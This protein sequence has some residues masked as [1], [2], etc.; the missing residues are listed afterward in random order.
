MSS[1][2]KLSA[3]SLPHVPGYTVWENANGLGRPGYRPG[4]G[5]QYADVVEAL[6]TV[7]RDEARVIACVILFVFGAVFGLL[8]GQSLFGGKG[9]VI[10]LFTGASAGVVIG[11]FLGLLLVRV[12]AAILVLVPLGIFLWISGSMLIDMWNR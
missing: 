9:A 3:K 11:Y 5:N 7:N 1:K 6:C 4:S 8:W 10:G 12:A 2:P